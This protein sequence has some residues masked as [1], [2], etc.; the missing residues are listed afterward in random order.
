MDNA[1]TRHDTADTCAQTKEE[2]QDLRAWAAICIDIPGDTRRSAVCRTVRARRACRA[3]GADAGGQ[4]T[5]WTERH[6]T[7]RSQHRSSTGS[8]QEHGTRRTR[9]IGGRGLVEADRARDTRS[10]AIHT[11][12]RRTQACAERR[13]RRGTGVAVQR[14]NC[15]SDIT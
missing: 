8:D 1:D 3:S 12:A 13:G 9:D 15:T 10:R 4:V 5:G 2:N 14:T 11:V 7:G 6:I